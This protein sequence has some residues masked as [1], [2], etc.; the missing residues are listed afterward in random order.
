MD[1]KIISEESLTTKHKVFI[2]DVRVKR[3][4]RRRSHMRRDLD[5]VKC[6]K[7]EDGNVLV[8]EKDIKD[9]WNMYFY[10]LFNERYD[11]SPY[12]IL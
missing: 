3:R 1:Y 10:N 12:F 5:Q 4:V 6:V 11:I 9:M 8:Q 2:M 7:D